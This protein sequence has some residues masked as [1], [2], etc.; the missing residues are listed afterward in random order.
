MRGDALRH[1]EVV[2]TFAVPTALFVALAW[3]ALELASAA[4]SPSPAP[5]QAVLGLRA[6]ATVGFEGEC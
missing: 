4:W 3:I 6:A 2:L 1:I 5:A